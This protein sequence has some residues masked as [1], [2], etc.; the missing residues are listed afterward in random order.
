MHCAGLCPQAAVLLLR[1]QGLQDHLSGTQPRQRHMRQ[2][3]KRVLL[4][5]CLA[6]F[7]PLAQEAAFWE[8]HD[9]L[10]VTAVIVPVEV[11]L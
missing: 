4:G 10:S 8:E 11:V 2:V 7:P 9:P 3:R 1:P 6:G 5:E